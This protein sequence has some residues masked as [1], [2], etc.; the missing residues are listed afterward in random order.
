VTGLRLCELPLLAYDKL[1]EID[2]V[3]LKQLRAG[4]GNSLD[5][6]QTCARTMPKKVFYS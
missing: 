5:S 3:C 6:H 4:V 1:K 2:Q